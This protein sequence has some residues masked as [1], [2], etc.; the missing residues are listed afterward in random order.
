[1]N[2]DDIHRQA[3]KY[4]KRRR[5]GRGP[6]SG[7]G[8]TSGRGHKG[9]GSR[10]GF[11]QHPAFEGG[12][13]P[14]IRRIPKRGFNNRWAL[15]V[16]SVNVAELEQLFDDGAEITPKTLAEKGR[17][18]RKFDVLKILGDGELTKKFQVTAHRFSKSAQEKIEKAGGSTNVV[19]V[20]TP[21]S[22]RAKSEKRANT[23]KTAAAKPVPAAEA[24]TAD[25][26]DESSDE[27]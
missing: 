16:V 25:G 3:K 27:S 23:E 7:F 14:M 4:K 5:I 24:D 12:R 8:K 22:D 18:N 6:G 17:L 15:T 1:M 9:Q 20:K 13:M 21:V 2:L 10:A 19:P 11:R 26:P